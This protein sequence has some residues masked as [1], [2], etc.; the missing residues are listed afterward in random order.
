MDKVRIFLSRCAAL[1]RK[2]RLDEDLDEELRTHINF[3]VEE[4]MMRGMNAQQARTAA[5]KELGGMTQTREDYRMQR[6]LP[7]LEALSQ[8][9][10][11]A[12]RQLRKSPGFTFVALL[13]LALG[14]GA[15]TALFSLVDAVMLKP[16]PFPNAAR[17]VRVE[18][19]VAASGRGGD[20]SYPDFIDL[21]AR[22]NVMD[23]MAAFDTGDFTLIG[24]REPEHL[25]GA[26]VSAQ[27]FSLLGVT[28]ALGRTFR[29]EEDKAGATNGTDAVILSYGLWQR[30]FGS[31][32]SVLN[33]VLQIGDRRFTVVGVM[34]QRFQFPIQA[35][36]IELW[37]TIA[38]DS[39]GGPNDMT[40]Q[41]GAHYLD[42]V[43][44]LKHG[45]TSQQAQAEL[46]TIATSL[47]REHPENKPR[48][49]RIVP[50]LQLLTGDLRTPM[51]ALLGAVGCV[52]LMVCANIAN[53]LLA[54]ATGRRKEMAV[55]IALGASRGRVASQLLVESLVLGLLGGGLGLGLALSSF[56]FLVQIVPDDIPRLGTIGLDARLLAFA[57]LVSLL[58]GL[59]FGL[60]P[61]LQASKVSLTESLK[62]TGRSGD[63][64]DR[65][66]LQSTL[67]VS[68]IALAVVLLLGAGLL[69][70]S[71]LHL[72]RVDPGFDPHN[73][74]TFQLDSPAGMKDTQF[75]GFFRE[76]VS[77]I[78]A[79]P[80]VTSASTAAY[81]PLTG[82]HISTSIEIEGQPTPMAS[83]PSADFT[84]IEPN[85]FRTVGTTMLNG[86]DFTA[87]DNLSST[88]V[89]IVNQALARTF[90][91]NQNPI[92]KHVR[93]GIG[94]GYGSD[95]ADL[96]MREIVGV[97]EDMKQRGP[98][99][100]AVPE[101]YAPLA[102]S[103]FDTMFIL[104]RTANDP[105]S[106]VRA[107]RQQVASLDKNLPIYHVKTL[108]QYFAD[109]VAE[110]RFGS[111]LLGTFAGLAV[112]LACLGVYGVV[113]YAVVQRTRE[114]GIR[115]AL[116][117][118][119]GSVVRS[120]LYRGMLL[121]FIGVTIGLA[122]SFALVHLLSSM[123][124]GVQ[125]TDPL[126]FA[127]AAVA[128]LGVAALASYVPARRA[129]SIDPMQ[130]LRTE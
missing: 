23:G 33:S 93:P 34:P 22:N 78:A 116:G 108:D 61:A 125:A 6:G 51:F 29:D 89:V 5:L 102:Q 104:A 123:L 37:T 103:P 15:T 130:A 65:A 68:E 112:L 39:R 18:S 121:A 105:A 74:L 70:Q 25:R 91:P 79:L 127:L 64:Q 87:Q 47:N 55:R 86:R 13:T 27:L 30:E 97:I 58:S 57:V 109:S 19:I 28:P 101:V 92:G 77:R 111:L 90:F 71:F 2:H 113:S 41:R 52:L 85:Y 82:D 128:L 106:L 83:R 21:R 7:F 126:T 75:P 81:L 117:A 20:A 73:V 12:L 122:G 24:Q 54:R 66:R 40:V 17:L 114:I 14:I 69:L 45:V 129:A 53:L 42:V 9:V 8:D 32:A 1:L 31:D 16:L 44:L 118:G 110:P 120:V 60:A 67:V 95:V 46:A 63:G 72:T 62:K 96:P 56:R 48:T 49:V 94:N 26:V 88:P 43:A 50:E 99:A 98:G 59:F 4:H 10:R 119:G 36:P 80:G 124:F 76:A 100:A 84:M 38:F 107:A 3:A 35:E 115:M 11:Y